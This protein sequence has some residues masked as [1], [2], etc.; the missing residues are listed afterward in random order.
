MV[1]PT[2]SL[3]LMDWTRRVLEAWGY[4]AGDAEFVADTLIDAN[5][6]GI[7]SHGVIR[8]PAYLRRID[9][10]LVDADATPRVATH[11][12]VVRVDA[13]AAAGQ[14]A[15]RSAMTEVARVARTAGVASATVSGSAHFGAAGYYARAMAELGFVAMVVSN[16][17]PIVVPFGGREALL[18]TNPFAFAAP[19][20]RGPVSLDMA[21]STT[22]MGKVLVARSVGGHIPADWGVDAAG[23][24]TTDP[25]AVT[26]L[27]PAA[28]PKGYGLA[29]MVEVLAGVLSGAAIGGELGNMYDDFTRPQG[30]GHWMLAI[31][32]ASVLPLG[33]FLGRM[34]TLVDMA[35]G[36]P[37][38]PGFASVLVPGEPEERT[39]SARLADGIPLPRATIDEL[40][41]VASRC[42]IPFPIGARS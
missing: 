18:G 31:D 39:R 2:P 10:G 14:L 22:A 30:V 12:S 34:A 33:E 29:F 37:A 11:G 21:T 9:A 36:V 4:R 1:T 20:P 8:L 6:R 40:T 5:L 25:A 38:A 28:G 42:G 16:S 17:E 27:L 26:S 35:H 13:N 23:V 15:A 19:G 24:P 7:D 32:V 3:D 41:A